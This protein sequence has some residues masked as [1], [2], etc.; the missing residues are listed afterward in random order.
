MVATLALSFGVYLLFKDP[1][2]INVKLSGPFS[3]NVREF[4]SIPLLN[5]L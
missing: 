5:P 3:S 1:F 4:L 2:L